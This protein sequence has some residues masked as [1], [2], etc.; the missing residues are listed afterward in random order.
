MMIIEP[1]R[2][3]RKEGDTGRRNVKAQSPSEEECLEQCHA[4]KKMVPWWVI[5]IKETN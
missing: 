1:Q 5:L 4:I 3:Q 2:V